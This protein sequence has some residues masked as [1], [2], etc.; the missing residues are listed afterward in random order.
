[1]IKY[2]TRAIVFKGLNI[3]GIGDVKISLGEFSHEMKNVVDS[4]PDTAKALDDYQI[5]IWHYLTAPELKDVLT[6]EDRRMCTLAMF[7]ANNY[8]LQ[9]RSALQV[10]KHDPLGQRD[11]LSASVKDI[12][13]FVKS[14]SPISLP[15]VKTQKQHK[16]I[17]DAIISFTTKPR[18]KLWSVDNREAQVLYQTKKLRTRLMKVITRKKLKSQLPNGSAS[19][20]SEIEEVLISKGIV[21]TEENHIHL[22]HTETVHNLYPRQLVLDLTF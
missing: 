21:Q 10:A 18:T 1:L 8:M 20:I 12:R 16:A 3:G 9:L 4:I 15:R 19:T 13:S 7:G 14:V 11:N 22:V 2:Q 17:S 5:Q 6:A